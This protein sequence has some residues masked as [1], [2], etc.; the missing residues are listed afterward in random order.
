MRT[1]REFR[2]SSQFYTLFGIPR[3]MAIFIFVILPNGKKTLEKKN[4]RS[5]SMLTILQSNSPENFILKRKI[6]CV[7]STCRWEHRKEKYHRT[8]FGLLYDTN[9]IPN[10]FL[11]MSLTITEKK[12]ENEPKFRYSIAVISIWMNQWMKA[13]NIFGGG[14]GRAERE[15]AKIA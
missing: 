15:K 11:F 13:N 7:I 3:K 1:L 12:R 9:G 10:V 5:E 6:A 2:N 14:E 4:I 8:F